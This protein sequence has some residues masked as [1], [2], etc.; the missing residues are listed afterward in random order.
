[1]NIPENRNMMI[2]MQQWI[3][4]IFIACFAIEIILVIGDYL[5]NY[6]DIFEKKSIRRIWNIAREKSLPTWFSSIQTQLVGVT[7]ILIAAVEAPH[8]S[9]LRMYGWILVGIFFLWIGIDDFLEIHEKL[10]GALER[11]VADESG[12]QDGIAG[13]LLKN[14]SFSWH[15]FI[16]PAFA[17]IGL[18]ILA[19]L[20]KAFW[21]LSLT[22]Y[23]I[24][25]YGCWAIAQGIDFIEGLEGID[26]YYTSIQ[27][28]LDIERKY[29]VTHSLKVIEEV[30]E[31]FG[32]TLLWV[33][34]LLYFGITSNGLQIRIVQHSE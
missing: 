1:M 10:G 2:D 5:F 20:W 16:A 17:L 13:F 12:N 27:E 19:F 25:G 14:P 30:L 22:R 33:G 29:G 15:T 28:G 23:L 9:R 7:V 24:L 11:M 3:K 8:I 6:E 34:F 32:T 26:H 4:V 31:M 18:A 21:R